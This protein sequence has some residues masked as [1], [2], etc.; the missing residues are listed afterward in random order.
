MNT[1]DIIQNLANF[2]RDKIANS[3]DIPLETLENLKSES[4]RDEISDLVYDYFDKDEWSTEDMAYI[5][6]LFL[7]LLIS[8]TPTRKAVVL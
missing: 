1:R 2:L 7:C 8:S 3:P 5:S 6:S 4:A